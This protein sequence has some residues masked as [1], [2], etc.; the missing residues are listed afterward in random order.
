[1]NKIYFQ[2]HIPARFG[3]FLRKYPEVIAWIVIDSLEWFEWDLK[4]KHVKPH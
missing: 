2:I 1:M 3:E 4:D